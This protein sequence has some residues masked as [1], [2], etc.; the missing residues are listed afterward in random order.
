M[1]S[2]GH[3]QFLREWEAAAPLTE[4]QI[5]LC[6]QVERAAAGRNAALGARSATVSDTQRRDDAS[7]SSGGGVALMGPE[8]AG[9]EAEGGG[10]D[11]GAASEQEMRVAMKHSKAERVDAKHAAEMNITF[12]QD[13]AKLTGIRSA[14]QFR[15]WYESIERRLDDANEFKYR[16]MV[17]R[18][19][20]D[21]DVILHMQAQADSV[22]AQ[23]AQVQTMRAQ[24]LKTTTRFRTDCE[25][26]VSERKRFSELAEA[27]RERLKYFEELENLSAKFGSGK[28]A[29][30]PTHPD[31]L[32]LL[33]RLD[34]C[35]AYASSS[36]GS[37]VEADGYL[38]RFLELQRRAFMMIRD[39]VVGTFRT[40]ASSVLAEVRKKGRLAQGS[41]NARQQTSLLA[42]ESLQ[43]DFQPD[44]D[45]NDASVEYLRFR[46]V[47]P[48]VKGLIA[49]LTSRAESDLGRR[50]KEIVGKADPSALHILSNPLFGSRSVA[51]SLLAEC[52]ECFVEQRRR[53][54]EPSIVAHIMS[55]A[56][57]HNTVGLTRHGSSYLLQICELETSLFEYFFLVKP[58]PAAG[59]GTA[60]AIM[61]ESSGASSALSAQNQHTK[62]T[63]AQ[64]Y[65]MSAS[66]Q[67]VE[68]RSTLLQYLKT[69]CMCFYDEIRPRILKEDDLEKLVYL[70][71]ILRMEML[72]D[73]IPRHGYTGEAL[74]TVVYRAIADAQERIIFRAEVYLRDHIKSFVPTSHDLDYPAL[75]LSGASSSRARGGIASA[76]SESDASSAA[77]RR[78]STGYFSTWYPPV[79]HTLKLL[80]ML[81][82]CIDAEV[83]SGIAQEAV[84]ACVECILFASRKIASGVGANLSATEAA[85]HAQCFQ[86]WQLLMLREQISPFDVDFAY[87]EKELDFYELRQ[88]LTHVLRGHV[89]FRALAQPPAATKERVVDSKRSLEHELRSACEAFILKETRLVLD[90][91]LAFLAKCNAVPSGS[92]QVADPLTAAPSDEDDGTQD[93][94]QAAEQ[95]FPRGSFEQQKLDASSFAHPA[96]V[97]ELWSQVKANVRNK[98]VSSV[99]R[100]HLYITKPSTRAVLLRPLY[101][102][103][104]EACRELVAL[105]QMRYTLEEQEIIGIDGSSVHAVLEQIDRII[106][107]GE[108]DAEVVAH[109]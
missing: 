70:I 28:D 32:R 18:L 9:A 1:G 101:A 76:V 67:A 49:E 88:L 81:Y 100:L 66:S 65:S 52:G 98:L 3:A 93:V 8:G 86:I 72:A 50:V 78:R 105:L 6:A 73:E 77:L 108:A 14:E 99:Q 27:L 35:I 94:L 51:I 96:R 54:I 36:S 55:L 95:S 104:V 58:A 16:D 63:T 61:A 97:S 4:K 53:V 64:T 48:S 68:S 44:G 39:Y 74:S 84:Q 91:I 41:P 107:S 43:R 83:F 62:K 60:A 71:E 46:A 45:L 75:L 23:L 42:Q 19:A 90:P 59:L 17:S 34:E 10:R 21:R 87:T 31:F 20:R 38:A 79:E 2:S 109:T 13:L 89:T 25:S 102:N 56:D 47:A 5:E 57:L 26:L 103:C 7:T 30:S 37:V 80:S 15:E 12:N 29:I 11:G 85:E 82:R 92:R 69:L 22:V 33:H 40:V 24:I 106:V